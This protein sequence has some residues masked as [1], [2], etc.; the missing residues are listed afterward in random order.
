MS[1]LLGI[2]GD[3]LYTR[4]LF[5]KRGEFDLN[6]YLGNTVV[7]QTNV[8]FWLSQGS[9]SL[10]GFLWRVLLKHINNRIKEWLTKTKWNTLLLT[11][12]YFKFLLVSIQF[13]FTGTYRSL[14]KECFYFITWPPPPEKKFPEKVN[15][16]T[17]MV[18]WTKIYTFH[19]LLHWTDTKY[20]VK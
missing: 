15:F 17:L 13:F 19:L 9:I 8:L 14:S 4:H 7:S 3:A 16:W 10:E 12:Q 18:N 6:C 2:S 11:Y 1:E 5:I 20:R